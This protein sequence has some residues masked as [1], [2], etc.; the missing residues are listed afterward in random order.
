MELRAKMDRQTNSRLDNLKRGLPVLLQ[1][2]V[3]TLALSL[4]TLVLIRIQPKRPIVLISPLLPDLQARQAREPGQLALRQELVNT[5]LDVTV[6][7]LHLT[8][9]ENLLTKISSN[10]S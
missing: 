8:G 7:N 1:P 4:M 3:F 10:L 2:A 5:I 9:Y 6:C